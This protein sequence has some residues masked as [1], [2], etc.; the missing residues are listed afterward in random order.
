MLK[1]PASPSAALLECDPDVFPNIHTLLRIACTLPVTS[2]E[3]ERC[4]SSLKRL[5]TYLRSTMGANRLSSLA[6][7]SVHCSVTVDFEQ[8][9]T[10]FGQLHPRRLLMT[11]PLFDPHQ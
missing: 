9:V 11:D 8:I 7:M 2:A 10:D 5:K 6:L 3:N 1:R 4:N